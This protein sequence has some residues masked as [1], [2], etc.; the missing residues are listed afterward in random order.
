MRQLVL[1]LFSVTT[2]TAQPVNATWFV[3]NLYPV[4][5]KA[6]C[7]TCHAV[8]GVAGP[9]KLVFPEIEA[10]NAEKE[11]FGLQL[12]R[13]VNPKSPAQSLLLNK[14]TNRLKHSGGMR[15]AQNSAEEKS[16]Q[17]WINYL[18]GLSPRELMP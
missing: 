1:F 2:L 3:T 6:N 7:R 16:L 15:I 11:I 18:A 12:Q 8:D 5:E 10:N 17:V 4:L 9:T 13:W 14:P